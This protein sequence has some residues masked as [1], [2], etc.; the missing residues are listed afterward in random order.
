MIK[1]EKEINIEVTLVIE[2]IFGFYS[3]NNVWID[4]DIEKLKLIE[5]TME[6]ALD[7]ITKW[8]KSKH[9]QSSTGS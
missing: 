3:D 4:T 5:A 9:Q 6:M 2:K 8:T 7:P 1:S